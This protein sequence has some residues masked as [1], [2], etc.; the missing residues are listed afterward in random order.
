MRG[1]QRKEQRKEKETVRNHSAGIFIH[2]PFVCVDV[3][4]VAKSEHSCLRANVNHLYGLKSS[5]IKLLVRSNSM[6]KMCCASSKGSRDRQR[7][8]VSET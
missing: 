3:F 4:A 2:F 1:R 7:D 5:R 8:T 6:A